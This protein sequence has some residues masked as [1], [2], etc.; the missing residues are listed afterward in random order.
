MSILIKYHKIDLIYLYS[1]KVMIE[2]HK[3][4]NYKKNI[5]KYKL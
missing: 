2:Y 3:K 5:K 1:I 4:H